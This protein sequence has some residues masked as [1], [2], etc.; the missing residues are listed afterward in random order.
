[1]DFG[2]MTT[3]VNNQLNTTVVEL[4]NS[5][6]SIELVVEAGA[7]DLVDD[8]YSPASASS[9][10]PSGAERCRRAGPKHSP[11]EARIEYLG[12]YQRKT[13][14]QFDLDERLGLQRKLR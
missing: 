3:G 12:A 2:T 4:F 9:A 5:R 1:M 11:R 14:L 7:P 13:Y 8:A 10:C 6:T